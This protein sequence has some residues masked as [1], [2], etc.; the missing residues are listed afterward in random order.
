MSNADYQ[1]LEDL[2]RVRLSRTFFMRDFLYTETANFFQVRNVPDNP[3]LAIE[4]G[5]ALCENLLEPLQDTF[6][7]IHIRSAFR[8]ET[9]NQ[10][11]REHGLNCASN[12]R[13]R[14]AH[15][16]DSP[17]A[18]GGKGAMTVVVIPWLIDQCEAG[19]DWREI[20]WWI[21]DHLP[22]HAA[23]FYQPLYAFNLAWHEAPK[24]FLMNRIDEPNAQLTPPGEPGSAALAD[25]YRDLTSRLRK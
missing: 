21:H 24:R 6:G 1:A 12:E 9:V 22:Y 15:I 16:W 25:A 18:T 4:V 19:L 14:G 7:R 11:C 23:I 2:G 20:A 5:R 13:A 17:D 3:D 8:S 10:V